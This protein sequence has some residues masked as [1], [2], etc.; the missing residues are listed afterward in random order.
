V[1][2]LQI[3]KQENLH[4][5]AY[6]IIKKLILEGGFKQGERLK[7]SK[8]AEQFGISRGPIREAVRILVQEGLLIQKDSRVMVFKPSFQDLVE[9]YQCREYLESLAAK[10][11]TKQITKVELEELALILHKTKEAIIGDDRKLL[12]QLN[13]EFHDKIILASKNNELIKVL[14]TIRS[15]VF[16][17]RNSGHKAYFREDNFIEEHEQIYQM[18]LAGDETNAE[19]EMKRHIQ[20]DVEKYKTLFEK[21]F[22][23][24]E[25][26][27]TFI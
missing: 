6:N 16:F 12:S 10:L 7:E 21:G 1:L 27:N 15:K 18:I 20:T 17:I 23:P 8:L 5:Q 14:S 2:Y 22:R 9:L 11:A 13:T 3:I 25:N 24:Q 26:E 4:V 19:I